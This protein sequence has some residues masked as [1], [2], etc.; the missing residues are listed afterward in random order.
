MIMAIG[1]LQPDA[2]AHQ[3]GGGQQLPGDRLARARNTVRVAGGPAAPHSTCSPCPP[4]NSGGPSNSS[5]HRPMTRSA[6]PPLRI[7][8]HRL[9]GSSVGKRP[10]AD[11]PAEIAAHEG[12]GRR[13]PASKTNGGNVVP[14][15]ISDRSLRSGSASQSAP[16]HEAHPEAL[17][18]SRPENR[19]WGV[20]TI[21]PE[22]GARRLFVR[23]FVSLSLCGA[24]F[25]G[26]QGCR[27]GA[28]VL[29]RGRG[30]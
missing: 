19:F 27:R 6:K 4:P 1:K 25:D 13:Q 2:D 22:Y 26:C 17:T 14:C 12:D 16:R 30:A 9:R 28:P 8:S 3:C 15:T 29:S 7:R 20:G 21:W 10:S 11:I 23:L 24:H 18:I 5:A